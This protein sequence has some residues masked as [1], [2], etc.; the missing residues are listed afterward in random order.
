MAVQAICLRKD[1]RVTREKTTGWNWSVATYGS[2]VAFSLSRTSGVTTTRLPI[3]I[4]ASSEAMAVAISLA[5]KTRW[6]RK[7]E[8]NL[9][10]F[11][12]TLKAERNAKARLAHRARKIIASAAFTGEWTGETV[13]AAATND[14]EL[15]S[16]I[17]SALAI[18]AER[19][20]RQPAD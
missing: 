20:A 14:E 2:K 4:M 15:W 16:A 9:P 3:A 6:L 13:S 5:T 7:Q 18:R 19:Q 1:A 12:I 10:A 11:A 17:W 8:T